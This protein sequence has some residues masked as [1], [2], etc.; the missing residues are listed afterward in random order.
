MCSPNFLF[1]FVVILA[2]FVFMFLIFNFFDLSGD[3]IRNKIPL[4]TMFTYLFFLSPL[5][6]YDF[7]PICVLVAALANLGVLSK[8]NEVTAFKACGISLFRLALPILLV[9]MLLSGGLFAF[10]L[11]RTRGQ[12]EA[13]YVPRPN[14]GRAAQ[15]YAAPD[16]KWTLG[17][18]PRI[19]YYAYFDP[20]Q[21]EMADANVYELDP[22][23]FQVL[24]Q[25]R[26]SRA[27]WSSSDSHLG[28]RGRLVQNDIR[29]RRTTS[30]SGGD[31]PRAD[32]DSELLPAGIPSVHADELR[33]TG[34]AHRRTGPQRLRIRHGGTGDSV[35]SQVRAPAIC[36]H[37]GHDRRAVRILVG[38]RGA[39]TGIGLSI[40]IALSY[41][42]TS[43]LFEKVGDATNYNPR[44]LPG[45]PT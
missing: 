20:K 41:Q 19:Y 18:D 38:N 25:I 39:L 7:Y 30:H 11:L 2:T 1:Y 27:H 40:A 4:R 13:G 34:A 26:A 36:A 8:Q 44:W 37:H 14:Q 42:A 12:S 45:H 24:K 32:R 33:R 6:I 31:V 17:K 21:Q 5:A 3:M 22:A 15:T 28:L 16:R 9:A 29:R 23:T 35:L 43:K 10:E